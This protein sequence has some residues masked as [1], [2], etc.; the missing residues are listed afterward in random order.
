[1]A[2]FW[3]NPSQILAIRVFIRFTLEILKRLE[4]NLNF[5]HPPIKI[6]FF[7]T[8]PLK[9]DYLRFQIS[10]KILCKKGLGNVIPHFT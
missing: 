7:S 9:S 3:S 2:H 1:M 6:L 4:S 5:M 10:A 8:R